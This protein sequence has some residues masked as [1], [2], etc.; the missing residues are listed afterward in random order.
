MQDKVLG[1]VA[2][3][4]VVGGQLGLLC[5][6]GSLIASQPALVAQH[7]R[8][9]DQGTLQVNVDIR[10]GL[11]I[12]MTVRNLELAVLVARLWCEI[13]LEGQLETLQQLILHSNLSEQSVVCVPFLRQSKAIILDLVL[14]FQGAKH[15]ARFLVRV[16][17]CVEFNA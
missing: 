6:E 9:V 11:D 1:G 13:A 17:S 15:L 16:T 12:L 4:K 8:C 10:I 7:S 3:G 2:E 5:I 14:G